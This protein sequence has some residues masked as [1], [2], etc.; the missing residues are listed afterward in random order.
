MKLS[1]DPYTA[2]VQAHEDE[3]QRVRALRRQELVENP[4]NPRTEF[5]ADANKIVKHL[6]IIFVLLP[7]LLWILYSILQIGA[8]R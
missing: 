5:S 1:I 6:W 3:Q 7:L 4:Y 8:P 2:E